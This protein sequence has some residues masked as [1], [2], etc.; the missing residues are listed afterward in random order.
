TTLSAATDDLDDGPTVSLMTLHAAK[1]LE[2]LA[3]FL[4]GMEEGLFPHSQTLAEPDDMEEER[5]LCYVGITRARERLYLTHTWSRQLFGSYSDSIPSRFLKEIPEDLLEDAG[6]GLV[7]GTG[8]GRWGSGRSS[9]AEAYSATG[10]RGVPSVEPI[11]GAEALGLVA[12]DAV[13]HSRFGAGVVTHVEG[14]GEDTRAEVRFTDAGVKRFL[15]ALTPL[16][17]AVGSR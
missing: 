6:R 8:A 13:V 7:Y 14:D 1:G 11:T 3:V 2:F 12:G 16:E 10:S 4:T 15:L 5:R 9:Y 17:R